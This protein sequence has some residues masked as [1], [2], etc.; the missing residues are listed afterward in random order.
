M[1]LSPIVY[2]QELMLY[3]AQE[4]VKRKKGQLLIY[5]FLLIFVCVCIS[6][7]YTQ[8]KQSES[9]WGYTQHLL[10]KYMCVC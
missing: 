1:D 3:T 7:A 4:E 5:S 8:Q 9:C 2:T 10:Y 6:S